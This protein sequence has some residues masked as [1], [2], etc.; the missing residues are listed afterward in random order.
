MPF[1]GEF[2]SGMHF[3]GQGEQIGTFTL[4]EVGVGHTGV[5]PGRYEY[6]IEII[7]R[8]KG[9]MAG[10]RKA[11]K[12]LLDKR[13]TIFSEFGNPYQC[14]IGGVKVESLGKERYRLTARGVGVRVDLR[15]ELARFVD[16]LGEGG[17]AGSA[18]AGGG[19]VA[20]YLSAYQ[21]HSDAGPPAALAGRGSKGRTAKAAVPGAR[22]GCSWTSFVAAAEGC[23]RAAGFWNDETWKLLGLTGMAFHFIVHRELCPSSVTVYD[24]N[25]EHVDAMDR[26]GVHSEAW[27]TWNS[28]GRSTIALVRATAQRRIKESLDRG[29]PVL[30]WA[31]TRVL[32]F[33][34]ITGYDDEKGCW[35]VAQCTNAPADPLPYESLGTSEVP[36]LAYQVFLGRVPVDEPAA[37]RASLEF[38]LSEWNKPFHS[39]SPEMYASGRRGYQSFVAALEKGAVNEFGLAYIIGVYGEARSALARYLRWA[40][41]RAGE[42]RMHAAALGEA[43]EQ[44]AKIGSHFAEMARLAPLAGANGK[45]GRVDPDNLPQI[46]SLVRSCL[47][48]EERGMASVA[49]ALAG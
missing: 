5:A 41:Q 24:W 37:I 42:A 48:L 8:G 22:M 9:G 47:E 49:S 14:S 35:Q 27:C 44:Y 45:G 40:A 2:R 21:H 33:G 16:Y 28:P 23:L 1:A 25:A 38:G 15:R 29:I 39:A 30:A 13:A 17:C 6:P 19:V 34:M 46:L 10:A 31:P 43:A 12:G 20:E 11:L 7:L 18:G 26:I 3:P 36:M 32:E 4:E